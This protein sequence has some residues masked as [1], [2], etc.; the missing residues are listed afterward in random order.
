MEIDLDD[1]QIQTI[2]NVFDHGRFNDVVLPLNDVLSIYQSIETG[3][4]QSQKK[5]IESTVEPTGKKVSDPIPE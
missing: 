4:T 1:K 5:T 3:I 2:R